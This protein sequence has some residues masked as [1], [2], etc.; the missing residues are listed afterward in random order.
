[1][2]RGYV[3]SVL[4]DAF[5]ADDVPADV[6]HVQPQRHL[7]IRADVAQLHLFGWVYTRIVSSSRTRN[8]TGTLSGWPSGRTVV[9]HAIRL[10]CNRLSTCSRRSA[11]R[12]DVRFIEATTGGTGGV[13]PPPG[14][15]RRA[16][17]STF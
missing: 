7:G 12:C 14:D 15:A 8:H 9:N 3:I 13:I 4:G 10:R 1:V 17:A 5:D 16:A 6:G 2:G 11:G